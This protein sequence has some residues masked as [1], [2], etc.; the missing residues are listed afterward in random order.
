MLDHS[1]SDH[2]RC[3]AIITTQLNLLISDSSASDE[4]GGS[5]VHTGQCSD[6]Q[7][8]SEL[9]LARM[10]TLVPETLLRAVLHR[11]VIF[12]VCVGTHRSEL[13][14]CVHGRSRCLFVCVFGGSVLRFTGSTLLLLKVLQRVCP[15]MWYYFIYR[16]G[17]KRSLFSSL[18]AELVLG[19]VTVSDKKLV[20]SDSATIYSLHPPRLLSLLAVLHVVFAE[21]DD[22]NIPQSARAMLQ[23]QREHVHLSMLTMVMVPLL[24]RHCPITFL[25]HALIVTASQF[26]AT[27]LPEDRARDVEAALSLLTFWL[28]HR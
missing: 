22:A 4:D 2:A 12:C 7:A 1:P 27:E 15:D 19:P 6:N 28:S 3:S 17:T 18:L 23:Q 5:V 25:D 10:A 24:T 16:N 14:V 8:A 9:L 21:N 20:A 13:H 11:C 26:T